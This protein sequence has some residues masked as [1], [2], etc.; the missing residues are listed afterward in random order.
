MRFT[1]A[2][3][4]LFVQFVKFLRPFGCKRSEI[5]RVFVG[6]TGTCPRVRVSS[7][8]QELRPRIISLLIHH[9]KA[10]KVIVLPLNGPFQ[11]HTPVL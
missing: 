8:S 7:R 2:F 6:E 4:P 11:R 3:L 9:D 1:P 10:L 5:E